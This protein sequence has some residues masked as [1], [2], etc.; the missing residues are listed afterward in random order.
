MP[1][2][3]TATITAAASGSTVAISVIGGASELG[4]TELTVWRNTSGG[5]QLVVRGANGVP[6]IGP[7]LWVG[8]DYEAPPGRPLSYSAEITD[9]VDTVVIGPAAA[10]GMTDYGG[11]FIMPVGNPLLGTNVFVEK[12][13]IGDL[14]RQIIRDIQPVLN[15][16]SPV[17]VSYGRRHVQGTITLVTLETADSQQ[18]LQILNFP[19]VMLMGRTGYGFTQ[20]LYV[21]IGDVVEQRTS[22]LGAEPSRRWILDCSQ[23]DRPPPDFPY[24]VVGQ[25]WQTFIDGSDTWGDLDSTYPSFYEMAGYP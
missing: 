13:G 12:N 25:D 18:L 3:D 1:F 6:P 4:M 2:G 5:Q 20:P 24:I 19:V 10:T 8:T 15:R 11:D 22:G 21:S 7:G 16:P 17:A 14:T 9:G 23:V